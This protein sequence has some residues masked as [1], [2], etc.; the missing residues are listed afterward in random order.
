MVCSA[1]ASGELNVRHSHPPNDLHPPPPG[2]EDRGCNRSSSHVRSDWRRSC[3]RILATSAVTSC[4]SRVADGATKMARKSGGDDEGAYM[5]VFVGMC[6]SEG[7]RTSTSTASR[8]PWPWEPQRGL[9]AIEIQYPDDGEQTRRA[10]SGE[11][12]SG[13]GSSSA[14]AR[15]S[16]VRSPQSSPRCARCEPI[17]LRPRGRAKTRMAPHESTRIASAACRTARWLLMGQRREQRARGEASLA[18]QSQRRRSRAARRGV[19][20]RGPSGVLQ[21]GR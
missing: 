17:S 15:P 10:V 7:R 6:M 3:A 8:K 2:T 11:L 4:I 20:R 13:E 5:R 14:S 19:G 18:M 9:H 12:P 1:R 21:T 16:T